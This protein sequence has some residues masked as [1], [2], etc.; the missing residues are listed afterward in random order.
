MKT[1]RVLFTSYTP[2]GNV[3]VHATLYR[4]CQRLEEVHPSVSPMEETKLSSTAIVPI[5]SHKRRPA[6]SRKKHRHF[7]ICGG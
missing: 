7:S 6:P 3:C 2:H 4:L 5:T 1:G